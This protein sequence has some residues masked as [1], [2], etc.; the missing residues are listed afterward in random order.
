MYNVTG[1]RTQDLSLYERKPRTEVICNQ[2][3]VNPFRELDTVGSKGVNT[4]P[5]VLSWVDYLVDIV[6]FIIIDVF[7][8]MIG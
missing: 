2:H 8:E 4:L 1:C 7:T 3:T 5:L 6:Y